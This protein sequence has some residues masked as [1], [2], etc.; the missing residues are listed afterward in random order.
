MLLVHAEDDGL[1]EAIAALPQEVG[2][3]PGDELGAVVDDESPVEILLVVDA[4]LDLNPLAV[5]GPHRWAVSLHIAVDV[6]PDDLVGREEAVA[7]AL[8]QGVREDGLAEVIDVGG[9]PGLLRGCGQA[10]L[11]GAREVLKDLS[12]GRVRRGTAPVAL[13]ND[14]QVEEAG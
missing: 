5:E 8:P 7:D 6:N 11:R 2:H 3:L 12:P 13:I 14:D 10:D 1:L 9:V 4:V